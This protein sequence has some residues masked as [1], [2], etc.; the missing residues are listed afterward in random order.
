MSANRHI[1]WMK[2]VALCVAVLL[3]VVC[4][5]KYCAGSYRISTSSMENTLH[6]G[7][8]VLVNKMHKD[9]LRRNEVILFFSPLIKDSYNAPLMVSR[10]IAMPGDTIQVSDAGYRIN[11]LL[12]PRSPNAL[13][14]YVVEAGARN[15][16]GDVLRKLNIPLRDVKET[17]SDITVSLSFFEEY[18]IREELAEPANRRFNREETGDYRLIVPRKGE[19]YRLDESSVTACREAIRAESGGKAEFRNRKLFLDGKETNKFRFRQDYY[20]ALSDNI[21]EAIDSRRVGFIPAGNIIGNVWFCWYSKDRER[22]F[23]R[24]Y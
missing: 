4:V 1:Q 17:S 20:W 24:I 9:N 12:Y 19:I 3:A 5:R 23:K 7:D 16:F 10:C 11:G 13:S 21:N 6:E 2:T 18:R 14:S 8:Y 15:E 22:A